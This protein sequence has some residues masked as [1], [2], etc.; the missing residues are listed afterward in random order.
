MKLGLYSLALVNLNF[1]F[2]GCSDQ[3]T[4]VNPTKAQLNG[5]N[6]NYENNHPDAKH[7]DYDRVDLSFSAVPMDNRLADIKSKLEAI[8]ISGCNILGNCDYSDRKGVVH[9]FFGDTDN[10]IIRDEDL[11][12]VV[13][14][15]DAVKFE[16]KPI[17][18]LGIG[19]ARRKEDV[20]RNVRTFVP[21][22]KL[23][24]S[25]PISENVGPVECSGSINPGWFK[26]GFDEND[27]LLAVRFD[28]YHFI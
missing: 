23:N 11:I 24:C 21:N 10:D 6:S 20:L 12:L 26:I 15:L 2:L 3:N 5:N 27:N 4:M 9:Y 18:A 25:G 14:T 7:A 19:L 28:A 8:D 13:K 1:I 16:Q 22:V 17:G